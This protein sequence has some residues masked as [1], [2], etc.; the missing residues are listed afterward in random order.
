MVITV[1]LLVSFILIF[2]YAK[3]HDMLNDLKQ[4]IDN[5][6]EATVKNINDLTKQV[7]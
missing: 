7:S 1:G 6:N 4:Q 3:F 5:Q 2:S